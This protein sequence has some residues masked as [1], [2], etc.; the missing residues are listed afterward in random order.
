VLVVVVSGEGT[1][2]LGIVCSAG[3]TLVGQQPR[4]HCPLPLGVIL[5]PGQELR[6]LWVERLWVPLQLKVSPMSGP[7]NL[8]TL[9]LSVK[10]VGL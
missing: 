4:C 5:D 9:S 8:M 6:A 10:K 2:R 7:R 1:H 3:L